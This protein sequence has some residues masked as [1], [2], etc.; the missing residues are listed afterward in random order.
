MLGLVEGG[1]GLLREPQGASFWRPMWLRGG[2]VRPGCP[3]SVREDE[4]E[5]SNE[6]KEEHPFD[7]FCLVHPT[8]ENID[9]QPVAE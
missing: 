9:S 8:T 4:D 7:F 6:E 5:G 2:P 1:D 3:H